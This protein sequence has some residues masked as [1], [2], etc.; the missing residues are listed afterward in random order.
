MSL[1]MPEA[2]C[3]AVDCSIGIQNIPESSRS[4][5]SGEHVQIRGILWQV[6]QAMQGVEKLKQDQAQRA[7]IAGCPGL[8]FSY[9]FVI[10]M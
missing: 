6:Q 7:T 4:I 1:Q 3:T 10:D 8:F 2:A 5:T 9:L